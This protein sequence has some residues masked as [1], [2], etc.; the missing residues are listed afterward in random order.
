MGDLAGLTRRLSHFQDVGIG[1]L[2]LVGLQ[3]SDFAYGGTMM[4][5]FCAVDPRFG[6][7]PDFDRLLHEAHARGI[8]I[9]MGWSPFS[10]HPDHPFFQASRDSGHAR[11]AEFRDYFLWVEDANSRLPRRW[12]HWEW[13][14]LR[15][16]YHHTVWLT[17]DKRWCPEVNLLSARAREENRRVL[18]FWLE[19]GI[20]G[21]WV[22]CGV[23]GGFTTLDAHVELSREL[24]GIVRDGYDSFFAGQAR[25]VPVQKTVYRKPGM[26]VLVE[27]FEGME[28]HGIHEA[29]Y[30]F[31][32]DPHGNQ[33][34]NDFHM[35]ALDFS[36][37]AE[38]ARA[39]LG[40][41][42]H[43]TLPLV[44]L[45]RFPEHAGLARV[46]AREHVETFPFLMMWDSSP[47]YGFTTGTPYIE[48]NTEGYPASASVDA[49]L[50]D[51]ESFLSW[52]RAIM[53]LRRASPAL[54]C[55]DPVK[56]SYA[57][58]PTDDDRNCYA[59]L[60]R[61]GRTGQCMLVVANLLPEPRP[62]TLELSRSG[63]V[64]G[65]L[66]GRRAL[67]LRLGVLREE[68]SVQPDGG[69][70]AELEAYGLAVL[71]VVP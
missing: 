43:A 68:P 38:L 7:L 3:P 53:R 51:P 62:Y 61:C 46:K 24:T 45:Y 21:F 63:V 5:E 56:D 22:D 41:A 44:P 59:Y 6:T 48:Q 57:R 4:T 14:D 13:D 33:V 30:A 69:V 16:A 10:T 23:W 12:G 19:R 49:Q 9:L 42:I 58:V 31:Y 17:V 26:G 70:R 67:R 52:F 36:S 40:L 55:R 39:K 25:T 66:G 32:D 8:A 47:H 65:M 50:E 34:M 28:S 2:M 18:R 29:L 71:E 37:P 15:Q 1:A 64:D 11:H 20:D 35:P 54:Q 60:R 27:F